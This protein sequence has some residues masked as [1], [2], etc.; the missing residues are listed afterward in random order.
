MTE[1]RLAILTP[2]REW[3]AGPAEAVTAPGQDGEFGVLARHVPMVAGLRSGAVRV[4]APGG[5]ALWFAIDGGVLG[6]DGDG[7]RILAGRVAPQPTAE[8]AARAAAAFARE[9][10]EAAGALRPR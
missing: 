3:F 8:G 6:V 10:A 5:Q 2:D 1:F 4:R 7:A 9:A